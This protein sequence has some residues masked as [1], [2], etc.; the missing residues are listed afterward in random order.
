MGGTWSLRKLFTRH[1][2]EQELSFQSLC[3]E[4]VMEAGDFRID[5]VRRKATLRGQELRLT[6]EEFNVLIFLV[7][8]PQRLI[9]PHTVLATNW[10]S[11]GVHQTDFLRTLLSLNKKLKEL[12]A[13]Q[14]YLRTEPWVIYRFN[15]G[16]SLET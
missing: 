6:P 10:T 15:A 4:Q 3:S 13:D 7:G 1:V 5:T 16:S 14:E 12:A 9:T 8:H 2:T 11:E